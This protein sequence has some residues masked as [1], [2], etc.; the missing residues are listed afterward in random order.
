MRILILSF[1]FD[2]D[3]SAG[4][5]RNTALVE[6]IIQKI[7][8]EDNIEVM[9]TAPNRYRSHT[10]EAAAF[11][12]RGNVTIH[13]ISLPSHQSGVPDQVRAF[14]SYVRGV[15]KLSR[16]KR[17]NI[18]Y[19][20][21]SRLMTAVLGAIVARK[22]GS[23]L[24]LDI[25]DIFTDTISDMF[26]KSPVKLAVP[27]FRFLE[28]RTIRRATC[29]N[30]V[31]PAFVDYFNQVDS[32]KTYRVFMNGVDELA[33]GYSTESESKS[34]YREILYAGN[35][36]EGQGLEQIVPKIAGMLEPEWLIRVIGDG[37]RNSLLKESVKGF[38]NVVIEPPIQRSELVK[39]YNTAEVLFLHLNDYPALHKVLPS[40]IF[41]YAA[42][43]KPILAGVTGFAA[44]FL[45]ENVVNSAVFLPGDSAGFFRALGELHFE[46]TPRNKFVDRY[47]RERVMS[48]MAEDILSLGKEE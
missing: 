22:S 42:T 18:V 6:S 2:P 9:T 12:S 36:G 27:L 48:E 28:R 13:R 30:L 31:S 45:Q 20:S 43:G 14:L 5:F 26:S 3:L 7:S 33:T 11:E 32:S 37:G 35:I 1:Y 40:K 23:L 21:S 17:Y 16:N 8:P 41:E 39:R 4:S 47:Q 19:A 29:V 38:G 34:E 10:V 24:Y 46:I 44:K 15:F 25:R